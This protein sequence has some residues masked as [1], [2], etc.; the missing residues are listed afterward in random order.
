M[1]MWDETVIY[2]KVGTLTPLIIK[3]LE[4]LYLSH[5]PYALRVY[6]VERFYLTCFL[7]RKLYILYN[8]C[9]QGIHL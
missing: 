8:V 1:S 6:F 7:T 2:S 5:V 9:Q 3:D 4:T